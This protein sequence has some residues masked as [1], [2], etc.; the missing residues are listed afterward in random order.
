MKTERRR[1][2]STAEERRESVLRTAIGAFAGKGYFGTTTTEVARAAGISQAYV[3]R[4]FPTK[5]ALFTAVVEYCF[6]R[7]RAAL[8]EG[9]ARATGSTPEAVLDSMGDA[10]A[11]L[12]SDNDLLLVQLHAQAAA[13][14]EPAVRE[15][16]RTGYA[17]TVEYVRGASGA[18]EEDVQRFFAVGML[19]HL[20]V[21]IDAEAVDAP[22]TRTLAKGI[23]RY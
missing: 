4:L 18:G 21:S 8:E 20:L 16:V 9:A 17:R 12:I 3:Y 22:W 5:E 1:Q 19:C 2:L 6:H 15:A 14:S 10:Y 11:R 23:T 7:V 13:V